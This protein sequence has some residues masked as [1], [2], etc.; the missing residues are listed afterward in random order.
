MDSN[1]Y[2]RVEVEEEE[3]RGLEH[4]PFFTR[5]TFII[6]FRD[7]LRYDFSKRTAAAVQNVSLN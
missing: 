1:G 2:H 3:Y 6:A 7:L 4:A 5:K